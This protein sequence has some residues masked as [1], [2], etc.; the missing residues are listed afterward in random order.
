MKIRNYSWI[1]CVYHQCFLLKYVHKWARGS[2]GEKGNSRHSFP[3]IN[4][5][6]KL[7]RT[8]IARWSNLHDLITPQS[9]HWS[10]KQQNLFFCNQKSKSMKK[11]RNMRACVCVSIILIEILWWQITGLHTGGG[12]WLFAWDEL[13]FL[14]DAAPAPA[15]APDFFSSLALLKMTVN[16]SADAGLFTSHSPN[17]GSGL[18]WSCCLQKIMSLQ[19]AP[20]IQK[21]S[22]IPLQ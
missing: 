4:L 15:A 5:K 6:C 1:R 7:R 13:V 14:C 2:S 18:P 16:P 8:S 3:T 21:R 20:V 17:F 11:L 10:Q 12:Y 19:S 9:H 22:S